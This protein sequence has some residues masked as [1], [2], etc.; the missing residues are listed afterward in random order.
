MSIKVRTT[1][2][3]FDGR[4]RREVTSSI[5]RMTKDVA[6]A[7]HDEVQHNLKS[8]LRH[9]TGRYQRHVTVERR[10]DDY[11][12]TDSGVVYGSW[13]EGVSSRNR[14][15]RFKGYSSFRKAVA[16][17]QGQVDHIVEPEVNKLIKELS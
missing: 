17:V 6:Q 9:P 16:K 2:P 4:A 15:T 14:S 11:V 3:L 7:L 12:V 10:S 5:E 13:L 8:S 1:G